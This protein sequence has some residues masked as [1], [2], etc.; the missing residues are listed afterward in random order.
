MAELGMIPILPATSNALT[1]ATG[2]RFYEFPITVDK[3]KRH[4]HEN[5]QCRSDY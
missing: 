2:K 3:I 1:H 4:S 5:Q